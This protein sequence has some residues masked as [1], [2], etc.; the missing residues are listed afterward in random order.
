MLLLALCMSACGGRT[1]SAPKM[2]DGSTIAIMIVPDRGITPDMAPDRVEQIDQ[3]AT[4]MENDLIDIL[5]K[6]GYAATRTND[7]TVEPG[8][9]RYVLRLKITNY[10]A[11]SSAA[12]M[13]VGFGA[14]AATLDTHFDL[15][16]PSGIEISGDPSVA[17]GR[18]WRNAARKVNAQTV[19]AVN[20][21][22]KAVH[23]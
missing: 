7:P 19:D 9:G 20:A 14:G 21:R 2:A 8:P 22:L 4:W 16:G 18:D 23:R 13:F 12:R 11:G 5:T 1:N 15:L 10:N 3:L 17:S 6:T